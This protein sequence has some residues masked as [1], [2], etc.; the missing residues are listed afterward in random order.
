MIDKKFREEIHT[1]KNNYEYITVSN[2]ENGVRIY[3]LKM[4]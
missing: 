2:D 1:D 4:V 3:T